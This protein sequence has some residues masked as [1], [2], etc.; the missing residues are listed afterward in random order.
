MSVIPS[1]KPLE[2]DLADRLHKALRVGKCKPGV[3]RVELGCSESTMTNYLAGRTTPNLSALR[4]WAMRCGVPLEW[5][6]SGEISDPGPDGGLTLP[7]RA[8]MWYT[9]PRGRQSALRL[10]EAA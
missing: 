1:S 9:P 4:V 3:M 2:F 7:N 6:R 5:L 10:T 8:P